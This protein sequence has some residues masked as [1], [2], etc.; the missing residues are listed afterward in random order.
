MPSTPSTNAVS[1]AELDVAKRK[2]T[3]LDSLIASCGANDPI[4][5]NAPTAMSASS[6]HSHTW[7]VRSLSTSARMSRIIE[8]PQASGDVAVHREAGA[9]DRRDERPEQQHDHGPGRAQDRH[10]VGRVVAAGIQD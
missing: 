6:S 4:A 2:G 1:R 10:A 3:S 9:D 8:A 7:V 5:T